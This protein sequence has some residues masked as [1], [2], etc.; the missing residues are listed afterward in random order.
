DSSVFG[1]IPAWRLRR[2]EPALDQKLADLDGVER[3]ALAEVVAGREERDGA[4]EGRIHPEPAHDRLVP[5]GGGEGSRVAT[6]RGIV[7]EDDAVCSGK[8]SAGVADRQRTLECRPRR[9]AVPGDGGNPHT[10]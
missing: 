8:Q 6:A 10:R 4:R 2:D 7:L 3:C 9:D 5:A 1:R